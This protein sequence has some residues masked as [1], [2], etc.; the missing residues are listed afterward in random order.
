M[1]ETTNQITSQKKLIMKT[2]STF[3]L[4]AAALILCSL[5]KANSQNWKIGGN[6]VTSDTTLGTQN[7]FGLNLITNN[8]ARMRIANNGRV[9]I[10]TNSIN[11]A[12]LTIDG[13]VGNTMAIF[14]NS[15][16]GLSLVN[17][18]P[19]IGFNN[20]YNGGWKTLNDG[21]SGWIAVDNN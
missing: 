2:K 5:Q 21:F 10:G 1:V 16:H 6:I 8:V 12:K 3:V 18:I 14:G 13:N 20:Y 19:T 4:T 9:A 17:D 11:K 15:L 7:N